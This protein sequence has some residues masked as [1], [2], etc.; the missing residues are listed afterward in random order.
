MYL[1]ALRAH[2]NKGRNAIGEIIGSVAN[3]LP[4]PDGFAAKSDE[5]Q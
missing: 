3:A 4:R 1:M 5:T 2:L